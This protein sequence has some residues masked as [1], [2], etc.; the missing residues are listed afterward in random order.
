MY[1]KL[2]A[3]TDLEALLAVS[4]AGS[5]SRAARDMGMNQQTL[6]TR[7][8]RAEQVLGVTVFERSPYGIKAT[9]SG[10][11]VLEAVPAL[12]T[13]CADFAHN[14]EQARADNLARH[15]TVAVSNTVAEIHYPV[16]AA[17]FRDA[18][19]KVKLTMVHGNSQDVRELVATGI[20]GLGI[21]E[22]GTP[23]HDL[24]ETVLCPDELVLAVPAHHLW[25][26]RESVS[27]EELRATPLIV[28]EPGS[29]TRR[30]IEE[31]LGEIADPA[32]E[33]GSLSAQRAGMI[34]LGAPAIIPRSVVLD[35]VALGTAAIVAT[36]VAFERSISAVVRRGATVPKDATAFT[37]LAKSFGA[38]S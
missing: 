23:R 8:S 37:R 15:L 26:N 12:L 11:V 16:W 2:P 24:I 4:R 36:E 5:I 19:P 28:R 31:E 6:S 7:V 38:P 22:G 35:Q 34:A 3:I 14:V 18:H 32:G 13:A 33:F 20:A 21:V 1:P 10:E 27:R 25:A 30:V 9:E 17:A 29:G